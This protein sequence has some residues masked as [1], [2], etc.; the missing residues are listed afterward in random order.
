MKNGCGYD[1]Q[2]IKG[3]AYIP[4]KKQYMCKS[5][6]QYYAKKEFIKIGM[7]IE[8]SERVSKTMVA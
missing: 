6:R 8:D 3:I 4:T 7:S 5:I 2:I 1:R